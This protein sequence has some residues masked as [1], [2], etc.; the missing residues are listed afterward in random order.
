MAAD[1]NSNPLATIPPDTP[2]ESR[3]FAI[4]CSLSRIEQAWQSVDAT[5]LLQLTR[6]VEQN[7]NDVIALS[8]ALD[9]SQQEEALQSMFVARVTSGIAATVTECAAV[10]RALQQLEQSLPPTVDQ[11]QYSEHITALQHRM[12]TQIEAAENGDD[13]VNKLQTSSPLLVAP[14]QQLRR[15]QQLTDTAEQKATIML[16]QAQQ[17][18]PRQDLQLVRAEWAAQYSNTQLLL[19]LTDIYDGK[20]Q[21]ADVEQITKV[22]TAVTQEVEQLHSSGGPAPELIAA[23]QALALETRSEGDRQQAVA[24]QLLNAAGAASVYEQS[25]LSQLMDTVTEQIAQSR[26]KAAVLEQHLSGSPNDEKLA[27]DSVLGAKQCADARQ[28]VNSAMSEVEQQADRQRAAISET[29]A[30]ID[31][32]R[33]EAGGTCAAVGRVQQAAN[34]VKTAQDLAFRTKGK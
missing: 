28:Q 18:A 25:S 34:A 7:C 23:L 5:H 12:L 14:L 1:N 16:A 33:Q 10:R 21:L 4:E 15:L 32:V 11:D 19:K 3:L 20:L 31:A 27:I 24:T 9:R 26:Q 29:W 17:L 30:Q 8:A 13:K 2:V 6:M 22:L